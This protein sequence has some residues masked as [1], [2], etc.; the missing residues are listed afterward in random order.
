M[1]SPDPAAVPALRIHRL[2]HRFG[3]TEVLDQVSL[4]VRAGEVVALVGPSGCG[5]T[6][7]LHLAAG[8]LDVID[9]RVENGFDGHAVMFQESRLLPWLGALE[10]IAWGL[11]ALGVAL[12]VRLEAAAALGAEAGLSE[13]DLDKYPHTLSGGMRQRVALARALAVRPRLLLLD[14]P[15][16]ALDMGL[17]REL[18]DLLVREIRARHLAVLLVTHDLTEAVRL[19]HR[20]LVMAPEPGRI[21]YEMV[22][23]FGGAALAGF[24]LAAVPE[25]TDSKPVNGWRLAALVLCWIAARL[26]VWNVASLGPWP[27]AVLSLVSIGTLQLTPEQQQ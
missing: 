8:L 17:R 20:I 15:F 6:T 26:T 18:Q 22:F 25:F 14:E 23:G 11:K 7:L 5:K 24:L 12:E 16:S 2:S 13:D 21:V 4:M 1:T 19:S 9:G 3:I 10:N 27:A